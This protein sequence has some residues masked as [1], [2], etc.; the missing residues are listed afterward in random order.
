MKRDVETEIRRRAG[1]RCEYCQ[2]P[3]SA[4][5]LAHVIDHI[6]ARQHGG[7]SAIENLALCCGRCNLYKGPNIA[8]IDA[9]TR[10]ITRLFNPRLDIWTE[11]FRKDGALIVGVSDV[12]RTTANLLV[13]NLPVRVAARRALSS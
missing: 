7:S 2:F 11:H 4:G 1:S 8:G 5:G 9:K 10:Q 13:F 12:G 6:V 3:E